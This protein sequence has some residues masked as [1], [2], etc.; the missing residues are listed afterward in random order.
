MFPLLIV[1]GYLARGFSEADGYLS[2]ER[3]TITSALVVFIETKT[4]FSYN[5][6][7]VLPRPM[8][9]N[10]FDQKQRVVQNIPVDMQQT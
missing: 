5:T 1:G 2:M 4:S 7:H 10:Y 8:G 6:V 9:A 3:N